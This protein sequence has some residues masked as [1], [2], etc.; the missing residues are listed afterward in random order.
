MQDVRAKSFTLITQNGV[1]KSLVNRVSGVGS[2][3]TEPYFDPTT[4]SVAVATEGT[5]FSTNSQITSTRRSYTA[6]EFIVMSFMTDQSVREAVEPTKQFHAETHGY[7]HAANLETKLLS[8]FAS[9]SNTITA[10][11]TSGLTWAKIAAA[12]TKLENIPKMAPKPYSLVLSPD[13]FYYFAQSMVGNSNYGPV[14]TLADSIQ[15]KY[16]VASLVG[17]V[18]VYQTSHLTATSAQ[19]CGMFSKAAINMFVPAD[20]DYR[21]EEQRDASKRGYELISTQTFGRRIRV[22]SYGVKM[23]VYA[24]SPS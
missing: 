18:N 9:F 5:D 1:M 2:S 17:G 13:G 16:A 19:V 22:A 21:V 14:G 11:S 10:T 24:K 23:T 6:S 20:S 12:R 4:A 15:Q 3:Y 8:T 7:A